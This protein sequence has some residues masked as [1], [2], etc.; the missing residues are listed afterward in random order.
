M[1][2]CREA[3]IVSQNLSES[4]QNFEILRR[5]VFFNG[6]TDKY[7]LVVEGYCSV[8][9]SYE[10][11]T[12]VVAIICKKGPKQFVKHYLRISDNVSYFTE[13]LE[14]ADVNSKHYRVIFRPS[15]IV[16]DIEFK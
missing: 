16:P 4:A 7:L 11:N 8:D 2:S 12:R 13:Q 14:S 15:V 10:S 5:T 9:H 3:T 1:T 6:I